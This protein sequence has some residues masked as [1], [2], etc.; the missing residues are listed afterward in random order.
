MQMDERLSRVSQTGAERRDSRRC[1]NPRRHRRRKR[2]HRSR[3]NLFARHKKSQ[4]CTNA[5][6]GSKGSGSPLSERDTD[7]RMDGTCGVPLLKF[8]KRASGV[9]VDTTSLRPCRNP[10]YTRADTVARERGSTVTQKPPSPL[11]EWT[12]D[13]WRTNDK[14]I[15][16]V[17]GG[18]VAPAATNER[19]RRR[20]IA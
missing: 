16:E 10:L 1:L 7:M 18:T 4:Q 12:Y 13:Q 9:M 8:E 20:E 2:R 11:M 15:H 14:V 17:R 6:P 3:K 5:C 19:T